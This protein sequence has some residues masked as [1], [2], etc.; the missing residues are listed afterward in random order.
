MRVRSQTV[1]L[2]RIQ[3]ARLH[4]R[5]TACGVFV[6]AAAGLTAAALRL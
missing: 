5:Q 2:R 4:A 3:I 6:R 1:S